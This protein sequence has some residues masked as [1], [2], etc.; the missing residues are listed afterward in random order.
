MGFIGVTLLEKAR[1]ETA[2]TSWN[3][4]IM[5]KDVVASVSRGVNG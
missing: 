2:G 4:D 5:G 1:L 3:A